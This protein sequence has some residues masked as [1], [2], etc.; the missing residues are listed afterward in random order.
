MIGD[1]VIDPQMKDHVLSWAEPF[2]VVVRRLEPAVK[3]LVQWDHVMGLCNRFESTT[4]ITALTRRTRAATIPNP[5]RRGTETGYRGP[6]P[7]NPVSLSG[8][9]VW[10]L[11]S[12]PGCRLR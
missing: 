10:R 3:L 9:G 12:G 5:C 4:N 2:M 7:A 8:S 1:V 11:P 6:N